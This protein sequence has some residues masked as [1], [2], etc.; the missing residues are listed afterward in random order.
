MDSRSSLRGRA[1]I[2]LLA[3]TL[4][5]LSTA[6]VA[7]K[8]YPTLI[9][10]S[11]CVPDT[12]TLCIA[13][14][15]DTWEVTMDWSRLAQG[16]QAQAVDLSSVG[17]TQGG[18]LA[19]GN[20]ANPEVLIK[21]LDFCALGGDSYAVFLAATTDVGYTITVRRVST[22]DVETY[23]NEELNVAEPVQDVLT[24]FFCQLATVPAEV[25]DI[26]ATECADCHQSL[27][28]DHTGAQVSDQCGLCHIPYGQTTTPPHTAT[29]V[30]C[31][32]CHPSPEMT[33]FYLR[34][35]DDQTVLAAGAEEKCIGCHRD[36]GLSSEGKGRPD[37]QT[38]L[39]ILASVRQGT[40]RAWIQPGGFM[41]HY[42]NAADTA[43]LT[44]WVDTITADRALDYDPSLEA[45]W[46]ENDLEEGDMLDHPVW[47]SATLHKVSAQPTVFTAAD[48]ID[49]KALYSDNY[50][51][52]RVEYDDSTL[53]MTRSGSWLFEDGSWRH[54]AAATDNDK[55][56]EDRVSIIWNIDTPDFYEGRGCAIKCHGNVPGSS[57]FTDLEG[58]TMDIW[59][60]KAARGL[61]VFALADNG[62]LNID[63]ATE[64]FEVTAGAV[65]FEGVLD[66][67]WLIWYMN[68]ENGYDTEDSGR[69]GDAGQSAYGH[70]RTSDKANPAFIELAPESWSDAMVLLQ[71]EIDSGEAITADP[72]SA[73][74]NASAVEAAWDK[75]VSLEAIVPE[76]I[77]REPA[78]SR[79]DV[80]HEAR[81]VDG[82]W[83][84]VFRRA[85]M[86]GNSDDVQFDLSQGKQFDFSIA[87]FDNC[88]RGEIPPGHTTYGEGQYQILRFK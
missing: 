18:A 57:E 76:R 35:D 46:I 59:H 87:V 14:H 79:A 31:T 77:L 43:V 84:N 65:G 63:T 54:P 5:A 24:K 8:T 83:V 38:D 17:I 71:D 7:E 85:L 66:D 73:D 39:D 29:T 40:L 88:G 10:T 45:M 23:T 20:I 81:W 37:L 22:G 58:S 60:S 47:D 42:L 28:S 12:T 48:N 53:S 50:L 69:R 11:A 82:T 56:S 9:D 15:G 21:V 67:K 13:A 26:I 64:A 55:Q 68:L 61:G 80:L 51:Y 36:G 34:D 62:N 1:L 41:A 52:V 19:F 25:S 70:N 2:A 33:H 30:G 3:I 6:L 4:F 27:P 49:M 75:Y 32:I 44:D 78:G 86:T 72:A 16:G 74:Y